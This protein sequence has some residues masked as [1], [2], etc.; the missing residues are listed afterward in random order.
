MTISLFLCLLILTGCAMP[1]H[2]KEYQISRDVELVN[3]TLATTT[4]KI[5]KKYDLKPFGAGV[6][7]PGGPIRELVLCFATKEPYPKEKLR[8]LLIRCANELVNQVNTNKEIQQFLANPPFAENNVQIIIYNYDK[9]R[10]IVHD[11]EISVAEMSRGILTYQSVDPDNTFKYKNEFTET[12]EEALKAWGVKNCKQLPLS[13]VPDSLGR[14]E[15][16]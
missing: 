4:E 3:I 16:S 5:K 13:T 15:E 1:I 9:T 10:R 14:R 12:Y 7:M 6:A 2:N 11:P 8:D